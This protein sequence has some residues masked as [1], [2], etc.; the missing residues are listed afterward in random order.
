MAAI[1]VRY[2]VIRST[3]AERQAVSG[4]PRK[5]D[6]RRSGLHFHRSGTNADD[7]ETGVAL[8]ESH[9]MMT[10][11]V[12]CVLFVA[13]ASSLAAQDAREIVRR[14]VE[15]DQQNRADARNYTYL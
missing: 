6:R 8:P 9:V 14:A 12:T 15:R 10:R 2:D 5:A 13:A 4:L 3:A 11:A 1:D 7:C